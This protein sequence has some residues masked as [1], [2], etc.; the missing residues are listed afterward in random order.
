MHISIK[1]LH[2]IT[3]IC[4]FTTA[5]AL[6]FMKSEEGSFAQDTRSG[7]TVLTQNTKKASDRFH[8]PGN[9]HTVISEESFLIQSPVKKLSGDDDKKKKKKRKKRGKRKNIVKNPQPVPAF[10]VPEKIAGVDYVYF[11]AI[12]DQG[13]GKVGQYKVALLMNEKARKDSL[14]FV[15]TLGDNIYDDGVKSAHDPQWQ[16]KFVYPYDLSHLDVTFYATL[17]NH[18]YHKN[19]APFQVEFA[20]INKKWYMPAQYYTFTK[21]IDDAHTIQFFALHTTPWVSNRPARVEQMIW[22]EN[23]L[24]K[25]L[26]TWKIVFGHHPVFSY[27]SHGHEKNLIAELR[28]LLEKYGVDL[29]ING[30]D[31]DRQLLEPVGGVHYITSGTGAKSRDAAYGPLTIFAETNLGFTYYRVSANQ[32]HI[33]FINDKGEIEFAHSWEKGS[34]KGKPFVLSEIGGKMDGKKK[35]NKKRNKRRNR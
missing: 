1:L 20:K 19:R 16:K 13:T 5:F 17:G 12:G 24:K 31:H 23:E 2:P 3:T 9:I 10:T 25:S 29:Y 22:L 6:T 4:V 26:A 21:K 14:H 11:I 8:S 33:Q 18:D 32:M 30:H 35:K 28:P 34:I 15:L 27:G 7:N